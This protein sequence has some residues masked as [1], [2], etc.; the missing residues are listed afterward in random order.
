MGEKLLNTEIIEYSEYN[1]N[2]KNLI[3]NIK[4]FGKTKFRYLLK[5]NSRKSSNI[6]IADVKERKE[7]LASAHFHHYVWTVYIY[8]LVWS[9]ITSVVFSLHCSLLTNHLYFTYSKQF[10]TV[11]LITTET[12][13]F[14]KCDWFY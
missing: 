4:M 1:S 2:V 13:V 11:R 3:L 9:S 5:K 6:S 14:M 10:K 8:L 7:V 12:V